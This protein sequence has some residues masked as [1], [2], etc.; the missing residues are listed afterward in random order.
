MRGR[1]VVGR[2]SVRVSAAGT[3]LLAVSLRSFAALFSVLGLVAAQDPPVAPA[4]VAPAPAAQAQPQAPAPAAAPKYG[5]L[6]LEGSKLR[7]WPS[8]V[9]APPVFEDVL[10]KDQIVAVG[11]SESGF[12]AIVL[13]LGP[14][15]YVNKKFATVDDA[16][17]VRTKGSKVAFRYK[18]RTNEAP[19][20]QLPDATELAVVGEHEDWWRVRVGSVDA[21]LPEA[22]VQVL[23]GADAATVAAYA[24]FEATQRGE[25]QA[26]LDQIAAQRKQEAQNSADEAAVQVVQDAFANEMKKPITEQQYGPL[27]AALGKLDESLAK[28]SSAKASIASLRQRIQAQKWIVEASLAV[29]AKAPPSTTPQTPPQ[30]KDELE[31]FQS[32]GWL[33]YESRLAGVGTYY[34]EKGGIRQHLI[35]CSTGRYDLA[36]FV[37]REVGVNGPRRRP[38]PESLSVLDVERLEVLGVAA[39]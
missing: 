26:R 25:V 31:R 7:C 21:W 29:D 10:A 2:T 36:L 23:E 15:G 4:P 33:R 35:S 30:P 5:K 32:I 37:N 18:P 17:V 39:K 9:V 24:A 38:A 11:R 22:E 1:F 20:A 3:G 27:E 28:E 8:A 19:V 6:L 12:R 16:G 14:L 34:L 13:P